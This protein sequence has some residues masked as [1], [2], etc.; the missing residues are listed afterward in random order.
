M[1]LVDIANAVETCKVFPHMDDDPIIMQQSVLNF[2]EGRPLSCLACQQV[3]FEP[4]KQ[5]SFCFLPVASMKTA[6]WKEIQVA[7]NDSCGNIADA[8]NTAIEHCIA[9][10]ADVESTLADP[11][12]AP[13]QGYDL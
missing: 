3:F 5:C 10:S 8:V 1:M 2:P 13:R 12:D 9:W 4:S 6:L 7:R 11:A